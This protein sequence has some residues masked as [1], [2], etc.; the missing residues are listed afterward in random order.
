MKGASFKLNN[1]IARVCV[2]SVM[3]M[4]GGKANESGGFLTIVY[5]GED[6][7]KVL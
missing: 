5:A 4:K 7:D 2:Q 6:D 3:G 1:T